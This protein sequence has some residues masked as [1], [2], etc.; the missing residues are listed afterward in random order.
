MSETD[1]LEKLRAL[2]EQ[3]FKAPDVYMFKFI[4]P[5]NNES[6][7]R[8]MALFDDT[9]R[10]HSKLSSNEKYM[11]ITATEMMLSVD[12]IIDKYRLAFGIEGLIA[13]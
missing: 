8:V 1:K 10:V 7:A 3:G 6:M 9:S 13:L 5:N 11:S 4:V 2:L 12:S